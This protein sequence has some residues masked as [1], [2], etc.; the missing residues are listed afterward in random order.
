MN[1][2]HEYIKE[3]ILEQSPI[4]MRLNMRV[5]NDVRK[6]ADLFKSANKE[7][8]IVGGAVRDTLMNKTPKDYDLATNAQPQEVINILS[9][10]PELRVKPVGEAFGVILVKT[11]ESTEGYEIATFRKD[12]GSGRRPKAVE[13]TS[14]E[15]DVKR[16]DLTINALFYDMNSG[17]VV[18]YV[19][20]IEDI[21]NGVIR[22]VGDP[23]QRFQEDKLRILR[24]VRFAARLG[25]DL[26]PKTKDAILQDND[27]EGVTPER[28]RD[29]LIKGMAAAKSMSHLL[30]ML[31][32]L[33]LYPQIF[34]GL[35]VNTNTKTETKDIPVQ[36]ALMLSDN[37]QENITQ[38]LK[39]MKYTNNEISA[40]K[41]LVSF[42]TIDKLS[43]P[44]MKKEFNRIRLDPNA[45]RE[46]GRASEINQRTVD[47]FIK[48]TLSPPTVSAQDLMSRGLE[49]PEIG[50]AI[51]SAESDAYAMMLKEL[52][53]YI[54]IVLS[55]TVAAFHGHEMNPVQMRIAQCDPVPGTEEHGYFDNKW[56]AGEGGCP[57]FTGNI[58]EDIKQAIQFL[59]N[60]Q[61]KNLIAYSRGGAIAFAALPHTDHKPEVIFVAPAWKRG[62]VPGLN[63]SYSK[64]A[65]IHGTNDEL[66]PL[67]QS[68][69]LASMTGMPLYVFPGAG[70]VSILKYKNNP[71]GGIP[72]NKVQL[73]HYEALPEWNKGKASPDEISMQ[74]ETAMSILK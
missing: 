41:F 2:L 4:R 52:R 58:D 29:E 14:I 64:G 15:S 50:K 38:T 55:E 23:S 36:L 3:L 40:I 46:Y 68:F 33:N 7:F 39:S 18:D 53:E 56:E 32:D 11:P 30:E 47:T 48:F 10:D 19:G 31:E 51:Q 24:A 70:H 72:A 20:G 74:H 59:E 43:A 54:R 49:G 12:I 61:P 42:S 57:Q 63:P 60:V 13:F 35:N 66:V 65:I 37:D 16:R 25:S 73:E 21:K 27:L 26:D 28:I 9:Q 1:L 6:I 45:L 17:E 71:A 67:R 69:E 5:P 34:P 44:I 8:Y 62:W 22:A